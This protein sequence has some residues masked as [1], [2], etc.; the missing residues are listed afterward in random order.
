LSLFQGQEVLQ[1]PGF[2]LLLL[3]SRLEEEDE[4]ED[5]GISGTYIKW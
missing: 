4:D 3:L 5:D 2:H 1:N